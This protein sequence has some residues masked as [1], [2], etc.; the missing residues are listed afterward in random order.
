VLRQ[1]GLAENKLREGVT[2]AIAGEG[3]TPVPAEQVAVALAR[4]QS[5]DVELLPT[6]SK[7]FDQIGGLGRLVQG[8]A[9]FQGLSTPRGVHCRRSIPRARAKVDIACLGA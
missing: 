3:G 6:L 1:N 2:T 9:D 5:Y 7:M 4:C 8:S